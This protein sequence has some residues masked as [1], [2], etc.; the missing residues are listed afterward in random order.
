MNGILSSPRLLAAFDLSGMTSIAANAMYLV[1]GLLALWGAFCVIM[2]W[3]RVAQK[4]FR[5]ESEQDGFLVELEQLVTAGR[6][7]EAYAALEGDLRA[8]PMLAQLAISN[9]QN[10]Y[11]RVRQQVTDRFQRDVL[12]DLEHRLSWVHTVIKAAPMVGLLGTVLG[13]MGAFAKLAT[14][15][16][17]DPTMLAE[18]ISV[19]LVTTA[20]GLS[21]SIPLVLCVNS[22]NVRIRKMEDLVALG[23]TRF[24]DVLRAVMG[25]S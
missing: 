8:L 14:G 6:F 19:A 24:F 2:V 25:K 4:R 5:N 22:I 9:R 15:N 3:L 21:I 11:T 20:A 13:M 12:G 18:D 16:N 23:L 1:L 7:D 17:V 10:G